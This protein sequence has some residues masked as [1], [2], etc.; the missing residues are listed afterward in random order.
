MSITHFDELPEH[1]PV[2]LLVDDNPDNLKVLHETLQGRGYELRVANSGDA[3]FQVVQNIVPDLILLD[4]MMPGID[5]F[6]V[7]QRLK[8]DPRTQHVTVIFLSA[9]DDSRDKVRGLNLGAV[10][11]ISKP[12]RMDEV[13]ARVNT[14]LTIHRL[15]RQLSHRNQQL[16]QAYKKLER[17]SR[18]MKNNLEAAARVQKSLLPAGQPRFD[19][20]DVA[21]TYRPSDELGGDSLN[22]IP[23]DEHRV[24]MFVVDVVG[25]G[26]QS[27]LLAFSVAHALL[28]NDDGSSRLFPGE[29]RSALSSPMRV[30]ERLNGIYEVND[31]NHRFFTMV[32]GVLDARDHSFSYVGAG[33]PGPIH[34]RKDQF[35]NRH[36]STGLPIG[37]AADLP[38]TEDKIECRPGDRLLLYSDALYEQTP[39][40]NGHQFGFDRICD[41]ME[42]GWEHPAENLLGRLEAEVVNWSGT[43]SLSDDLSMIAVEWR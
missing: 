30:A 22:I 23:I 3:A 14:H 29:G 25:H 24:A 28:P 33:H 27:S 6:E 31:H 26:V 36:H 43:E 7:C 32:Y 37:V 5:G 41:H 34:A 35:V 9:L 20:L 1:P 19:F 18:R 10:D 17:N 16:E 12:Y 11:F 8:D 13:I 4:V 42:A 38:T 39:V 15:Q 21:W 2:I 40:G